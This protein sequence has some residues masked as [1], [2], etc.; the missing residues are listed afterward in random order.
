MF[1]G[2]VAADTTWPTVAALVAWLN[3]SNGRGPHET[4]MRLLK[5]AEEV[6]EVS[7]AY[8]GLQGQNP[9]K[10]QTHTEA[11]VADELCDV[12][13]T[14]MVALHSFAQDPAQHF[15]AKIQRIADRVNVKA[16]P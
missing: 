11:D 8:I 4:A 2:A 7:Q 13:V 1:A 10:G 16:E 3:E 12:V 14:A 5:L 6:G 15:A 9:R